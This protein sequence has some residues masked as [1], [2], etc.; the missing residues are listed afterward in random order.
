M[1][2]RAALLVAPI[3]FAVPNGVAAQ[4]AETVKTV[5][6][7]YL[8]EVMTAGNLD[9]VDELIAEDYV[10]PYTD[11]VAGRGAFKQRRADNLQWLNDHISGMVW[12][13]D[14]LLAEGDVG[15]AQG[16]I[17]GTGM[18]GGPIDVYYFFL[19]QLRNGQIVTSLTLRDETT[20]QK[21][22]FQTAP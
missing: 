19:A 9:A 15:M 18:F 16:A 14:R 6:R 2:R 5:I 11:D 3:V 8:D 22:I 20:L 17:T 21:Q 1:N 10:S 12:R 4:D 13:I 7:R